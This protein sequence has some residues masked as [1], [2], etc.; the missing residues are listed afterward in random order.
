MSK[1]LFIGSGQMS[2]AIIRA[3]ITNKTYL[4][5]DVLINDIDNSRLHYLQTKYNVIPTKQIK[6]TDIIVLG[7]RPQDQ[8]PEIV[9]NLKLENNNTILIS[10]IAGVSI[11]QIKQALTIHIPVIR[12][13]PNT[14]TDT[15]YGYSGV[16]TDN[17]DQ[18]IIK[19]EN[20]VKFF[21]SFGKLE[22]IDES[23]LN[24]FT[25]YAIAGPNYIYYFYESMVDAGVLAGL[26]R[27]VAKRIAIENLHGA[28]AMLQLSKK[29]PREL[30]DI[31]NSPAGVGINSLY[32]LNN[33][34]FTAALQRSI[35]TAIKR[36][37]ELGENE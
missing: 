25:G 32:E 31:N 37:K 3:L 24:I 2:E 17:N 30:L 19:Q 35:Q 29:H 18:W 23:L 15:Q 20:V 21:T 22:Y 12:T 6:N 36:T 9:K 11:A 28:A 14:L 5:N 16:A 34:D 8:W 10:I 33:S 13:I 26:S 7:V 1:I 4:A 27:D